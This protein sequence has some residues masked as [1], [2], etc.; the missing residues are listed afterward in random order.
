[1]GRHDEAAAALFSALLV[2]GKDDETRRALMAHY[3][4]AGPA[5][6]LT[7]DAEPRLNVAGC[8]PL[9]AH[10]C[11]AYADLQAVMRRAGNDAVLG[12]LALGAR[13]TGC[14]PGS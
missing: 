1:M 11:R 9:H 2:D 12:G 10:L 13:Q 8:P 7:A 5:C 6:A 4:A 14:E 3:R